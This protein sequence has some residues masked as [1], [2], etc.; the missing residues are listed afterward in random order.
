MNT[1]TQTTE[2]AS[3]LAE[4]TYSR[5]LRWPVSNPSGAG[6]R[7]FDILLRSSRDEYLVRLWEVFPKK[8]GDRTNP[9]EYVVLKESPRIGGPFGEKF[10]QRRVRL[11]SEMIGWIK[12]QLAAGAVKPIG[13][14]LVP[15]GAV[16]TR[17][18][19]EY[20]LRAF[21][22]PEAKLSNMDVLTDD[23]SDLDGDD[24]W[25]VPDDS[26]KTWAD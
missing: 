2:R 17:A 4:V 21:S 16:V 23:L 7:V 5:I 19:A 12:A 8:E 6:N 9:R 3:L 20:C 11:R 15:I 13:E 26:D 24:S 14:L 22:H 25:R 1:E 10:Y 18:H